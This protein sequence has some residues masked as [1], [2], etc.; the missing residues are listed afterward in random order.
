MMREL[1]DRWRTDA[2]WHRGEQ[3]RDRPELQATYADPQKRLGEKVI[4][5]K[6]WSI[7]AEMQVGTCLYQTL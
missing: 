3:M 2:R 1:G 7:S 4:K 6:K 5:N